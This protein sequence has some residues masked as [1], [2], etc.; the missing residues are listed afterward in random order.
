[1]ENRKK[2][3][4]HFRRYTATEVV[5]ESGGKLYLTRSAAESY[6]DGTVR[7]YSRGMAEKWAAEEKAAK[8]K[9]TKKEE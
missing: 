7:E 3:T 8:K 5:Y 6:G 4:D 9:P 1:M 2:I